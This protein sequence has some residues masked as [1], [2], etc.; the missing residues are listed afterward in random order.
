MDFK[1]ALKTRVHQDVELLYREFCKSQEIEMNKS[2]LPYA[3]L[4]HHQPDRWKMKFKV[5]FEREKIISFDSGRT[6]TVD[7]KRLKQ[8]SF[9]KE[10]YEQ[11]TASKPLGEEIIC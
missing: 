9:T 3:K 4:M 5:I 10:F 8:T 2:N 11:I 7:L 1:N 6:S